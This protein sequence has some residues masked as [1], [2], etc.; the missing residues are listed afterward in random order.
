MPRYAVLQYKFR[1]AFR[2]VS[3][4]FPQEHEKGS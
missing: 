4:T 3:F 2:L 1:E